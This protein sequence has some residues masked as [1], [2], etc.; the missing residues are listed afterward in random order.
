MAVILV[1]SLGIVIRK[2]VK[3]KTINDRE[4]TIAK[5]LG[6]I[7]A[8]VLLVEGRIVI[9]LRKNNE[10]YLQSQIDNLVKIS[11]QIEGGREKIKE[12]LA[13]EPELVL[14]V[15]TYLE[16]KLI[17]T[18]REVDRYINIRDNRRPI[19]RWLLYFG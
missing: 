17:K 6:G 18:N 11:E 5:V 13:D 1:I 19:M 9:D 12:K 2:C 4:R 16:S 14:Y 15:D 8:L 7:L 10:D 3:N